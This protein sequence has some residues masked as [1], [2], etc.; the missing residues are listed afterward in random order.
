MVDL[1]P[2]FI[3]LSSHIFQLFKSLQALNKPKSV[4]H[5]DQINIIV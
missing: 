1:Q 4:F 2:N 3:H 5:Y